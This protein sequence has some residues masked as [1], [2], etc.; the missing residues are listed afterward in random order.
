[1]KSFRDI[2][3]VFPGGVRKGSITFDERSILSFE[4]SEN[5]STLPEGVF[6]APGF[7]D[8]HIHGACGRD[9]MDG[10]PE[11]ILK[12]ADALVQEGVTS[13][14]PTTM[15]ETIPAIEKSLLSI[16][17]AKKKQTS[18]AN[19]AGIHLEGPFIS[20]IFKGA[21]AEINIQKPNPALLERFQKLSGG[22]IRIVTFAYEEDGGEE[23]LKACLRLHITPSLGHSN[24]TGQEALASFDK[25]VTSVT[26]LYN[27]QSRFH[28]RDVGIVGATLLRD[29][30]KAEI[31]ADFH[32]S[33]KE[34]IAL[35]CKTKRKEDI[36]LISDSTEAKGLGERA[37]AKLGSQE[38]HVQNGLALLENGTIAGSILRIDDALRNVSSVAKGYSYSDIVNL[39]TLNPAKNLGLD[40]RLG[41]IAIGKEPSFAL[42]DSSFH[43]LATIVNGTV[44]YRKP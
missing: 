37:K 9:A 14:L 22:L 35:L 8:E 2:N 15:T 39:A 26:H 1:M 28:H 36:V 19:I 34:A 10:D 24:A 3:I 18:G 13:F 12:I 44:A 17:E 5:A 6:L 27:A 20:P 32:H 7:I 43:V 30:V 21:Q 31:I 33:S 41:S 38:I 16:Q 42:L 23:F 29:G 4:A 25:G 11:S 40:G